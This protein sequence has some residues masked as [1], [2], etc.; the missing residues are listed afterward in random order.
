MYLQQQ[1]LA[2]ILEKLKQDHI[3]ETLKQDL[4]KIYKKLEQDLC[5]ALNKFDE[6]LKKRE[7]ARAQDVQ[8]DDDNDEER[9]IEEDICVVDS[10]D[11]DEVCAKFGRDEICVKSVQ[12]DFR[13]KI[14][15]S[16]IDEDFGQN[17]NYLLCAK[18]VQKRIFEDSSYNRIRAKTV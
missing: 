3:L 4:N 9:F 16:Y 17:L 6:A 7:A 2:E 11:K 8:F 15:R 5:T 14:G 1:P 10:V 13:A 18:F 12:N